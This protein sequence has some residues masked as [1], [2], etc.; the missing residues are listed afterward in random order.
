MGWCA[1]PAFA[2]ASAGSAEAIH[3]LLIEC[4]GGI[5]VERMQEL[6]EDAVWL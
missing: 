2:K 3:I 6:T 1:R 4:E 5:Y